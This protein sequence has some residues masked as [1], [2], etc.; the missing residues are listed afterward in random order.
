VDILFVVDNSN[1]M[2][3]EQE[4]LA[5]QMASLLPELITRTRP[6]E[7]DILPA[8]EDLH[9]G[10]VSTDM[11]T[12]GTSIMTCGNPMNGDNGVLQNSGLQP[13]CQS[14]YSA[15]DCPRTECPW[16]AHSADAPD[17]GTDPSNP[18]IWVDFGC[19]AS[20]G[21][22]GCGFEQQLEAGLV[23]LTVHSDS[24]GPNEGFLR[25]GSV[26]SVVL[27][28]D[29]DDCSSGNGEMFNPQNE[30][31]GC[32]CLRCLLHPELLYPI[33][34]YYDALRA[35]RPDDEDLLVVAAITGIPVDGSWSP[36]DS[37][38]AL[39]ELQRVNPE[40]PNE[41][42]PSCQTEMGIAFPPVRIVD[43]VYRFGDAGVLGSICRDD[44]SDTFEEIARAVQARLPARC[45]EL[46]GGVDP[47]TGCR[48]VDA[49]TGEAVE[50]WNIGFD[51][52]PCPGG[53][54]HLGSGVDGAVRLECAVEQ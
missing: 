11:G 10:V 14:A 13:G 45:V 18:P 9:V 41:Q 6:S 50:G 27:V 39:R 2:M 35:L 21:T 19:I 28:T 33:D 42:L 17:D 25:E 36:G 43:L 51:S 22:G 30:Q 52:M 4:L 47:V 38:D 7:G 26:L 29:E 40:Y 46:P 32:F 1:S 37:L 12:H 44:W 53:E 3:E 31:L 34:R 48:L 8:V 24:G 5:R 23:A 54:L 16:L 20:L 49:V 15:P